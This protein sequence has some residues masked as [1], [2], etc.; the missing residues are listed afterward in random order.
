MLKLFNFFKWLAEKKEKKKEKLRAWEETKR[1]IQNDIT[2][3][4]KSL[5]QAMVDKGDKIILIAKDGSE[6]KIELR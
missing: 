4:P 5:L 1:K 2:N 3:N 6:Q